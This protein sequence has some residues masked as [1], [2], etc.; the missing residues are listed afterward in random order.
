MSRAPASQIPI[1]CAR[2]MGPAVPSP[3]GSIRCGYCG[4][5]DV[6]PPGQLERATE[7][8]RRVR[9]AAN[10]AVQM[11][12]TEAALGHIFESRG[13]FLRTSGFFFAIA[14]AL[15]IFTV[16]DRWDSIRTAPAAAR[17]GLAVGAATGPIAVAGIGLAL[18]VA[19]L[20]ARTIYRRRTR[21][22]LFARV[23]FLPG[24]PARC[25][26]CG[27][28]LPDRRDAFVLCSFCATHNLVTPELQRDR[29]RLLGAERRF[30]Q[31]RGHR[32]VAVTTQSAVQM[33]RVL[34]M[35]GVIAYAGFLGLAALANALAAALG[36]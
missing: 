1:L 18:C 27:G 16:V 4:Q 8:S 29:E 26:V 11:R 3:D 14:A 25:R 30:Y 21:P 15:A 7:L 2:C 32:I 20:V 19:L 17:A 5:A 31:D 13:A 6:L 22:L 9:Q 24:M 33:Q 35:V 12:G 10:A 36:R 28:D 34:V 23:P